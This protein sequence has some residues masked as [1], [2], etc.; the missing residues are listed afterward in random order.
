MSETEQTVPRR[1]PQHPISN[2]CRD[3]Q[4]LRITQKKNQADYHRKKGAPN[5]PQL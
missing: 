4:T 1:S 5:S 2:F 3:D